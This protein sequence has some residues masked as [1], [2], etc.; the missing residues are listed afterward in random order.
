MNELKVFCSMRTNA[1]LLDII[2]NGKSK[3]WKSA[4]RKEIRN[5]ENK[6]GYKI[7]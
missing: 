1:Y 5:R 4:A 6:Y 3:E 2:K 7:L